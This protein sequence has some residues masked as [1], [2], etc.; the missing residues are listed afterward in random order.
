MF[1]FVFFSVAGAKSGNVTSEGVLFV[2]EHGS[3]FPSRSNMSQNVFNLPA[4]PDLMLKAFYNAF[5]KHF[6]ASNRSFRSQGPLKRPFKDHE[7]AFFKAYERFCLKPFEV[8]S[9]HFRRFVR[10]LLKAFD[11]AF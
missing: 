6:K 5:K 8:L 2:F 10:G 7:K 4:N 1:N 3:Y 9:R 11:K